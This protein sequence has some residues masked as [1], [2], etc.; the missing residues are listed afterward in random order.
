MV[1]DLAFWGANL[2]KIPA[3]GWF[4]LVVAGVVFTL[5]TTW[6]RGREIL[7][8]RLRPRILP[9]ISADQQA[10]LIRGLEDEERDRLLPALAP[11]TL[12]ALS[13]ILRY[14]PEGAG[15]IM[16]MEF[17]AVPAEWT[18]EAAPRHV[19]EVGRTRKLCT[20]STCWTRSSVWR[21]LS[22]SG[23]SSARTGA[24]VF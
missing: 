6:K 24:A 7:A 14:P 23:S 21:P 8:D 3:G 20:R 11:D 22:P 9:I 1:I 13:L 12:R 10:D 18:V 5:M 19:A 16:T 4:P 17:M 15:G 2:V